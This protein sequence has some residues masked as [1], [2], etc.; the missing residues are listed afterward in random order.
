MMTLMNELT[1]RTAALND[2]SK[3]LIDSNETIDHLRRKLLEVQTAN[4]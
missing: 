4:L 3:Q 1:S 2:L